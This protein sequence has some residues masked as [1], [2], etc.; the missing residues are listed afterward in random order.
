MKEW[1]RQ[2]KI[3]FDIEHPEYVGLVQTDQNRW[4]Y[5]QIVD[6]QSAERAIKLGND[7]NAGVSGGMKM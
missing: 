4:E 1:D 7:R 2:Q 6:K 3:K 5:K